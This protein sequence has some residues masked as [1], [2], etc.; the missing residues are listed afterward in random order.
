MNN[1]REFGK[2]AAVVCIYSD[3]VGEPSWHVYK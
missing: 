1:M 3:F 2:I